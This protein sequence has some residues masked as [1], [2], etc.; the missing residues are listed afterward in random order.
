MGC[1]F[2]TSASQ[3]TLLFV[4]IGAGAVLKPGKMRCHSEMG[5]VKVLRGVSLL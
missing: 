3:A 2:K 1:L 4:F 5:A